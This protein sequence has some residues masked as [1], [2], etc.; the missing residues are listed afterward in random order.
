MTGFKTSDYR[1]MVEEVADQCPT[2]ERTIYLDTDDWSALV[3]GGKDI[4]AGA[5]AER[6]AGLSPHD[7]INIQYT[8]GTTGFPKGATLSHRNILNNGYFTTETINFTDQD[9]LCIPVP[10]RRSRTRPAPASTACRRCSSRC[11]TPPA[12]PPTT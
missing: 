1:A 7:A 8:S 5:V 11:S 3:E 12:S 4:P 6:M 2:L 10:C 9:R